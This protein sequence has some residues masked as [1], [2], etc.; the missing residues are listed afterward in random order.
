MQKTFG[1][2]A[3]QQQAMKEA[4]AAQARDF[5]RGMTSP[6]AMMDSSRQQSLASM[7]KMF[8]NQRR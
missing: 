2:N 3:S 6:T 7:N 1:S 5:L 4:Q 8:G